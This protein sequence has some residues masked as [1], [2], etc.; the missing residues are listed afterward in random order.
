MCFILDIKW[1]DSRVKKNVTRGSAVLNL[2]KFKNWLTKYIY[3]LTDFDITKIKMLIF[4]Q[5][6]NTA[7]STGINKTDTIYKDVTSALP[8]CN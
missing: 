1:Q 8:A 7:S 2:P 6:E 5:V 4:T 3:G